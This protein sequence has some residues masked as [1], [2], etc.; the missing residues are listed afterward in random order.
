[1]DGLKINW[2]QQYFL[3]AQISQWKMFKEHIYS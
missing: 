2:Y 3:L 1:M